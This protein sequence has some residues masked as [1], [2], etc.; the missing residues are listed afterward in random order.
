[1][2]K[3]AILP[4]FWAFVTKSGNTLSPSGPVT[5]L[6]TPNETDMYNCVVACLKWRALKVCTSPH[7]Q[8]SDRR[9]FVNPYLTN[10]ENRVSS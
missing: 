7:V 5:G 8:V 3:A 6:L 4:P 1:V 2:R 10:V 9:S